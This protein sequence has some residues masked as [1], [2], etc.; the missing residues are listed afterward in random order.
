MNA[1]ARLPLDGTA[2]PPISNGGAVEG[3]TLHPQ[4]LRL[5]GST[6]PDQVI[7]SVDPPFPCEDH[8]TGG[9]PDALC[10]PTQAASH[11]LCPSS[12]ALAHP[13]LYQCLEAIGHPS[14]LSLASIAAL[15]ARH[16]E[17]G[18]TPAADAAHGWLHFKRLSDGAYRDAIGARSAERRR[19][20]LVIAIA[21][22]VAQ[23]DAEDHLSQQQEERHAPDE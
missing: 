21:I 6:R 3:E 14:A 1:P 10:D 22:L 5:F 8:G 2:C 7:V 15:R 19:E 12:E 23:L 4:Y 18:H 16:V 13:G 17:K 9:S 11:P 20:R